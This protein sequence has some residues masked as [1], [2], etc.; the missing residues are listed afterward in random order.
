MKLEEENEIGSVSYYIPKTLKLVLDPSVESNETV[1]FEIQPQLQMFDFINRWV[2]NVGTEL[3]PWIVTASLI[4]GTGDPN[5]RLE[6]NVSVPI[7]KW[8]S[9]FY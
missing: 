7:C 4:P 8:H 6:G 5:A 2:Q 9:K 3:L 1:P